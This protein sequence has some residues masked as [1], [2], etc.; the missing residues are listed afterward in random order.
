MSQM[1]NPAAMED[2]A[3]LRLRPRLRFEHSRY[4]QAPGTAATAR[5]LNVLH[6]GNGSSTRC[7]RIFPVLQS[8]SATPIRP[9]LCSSILARSSPSD[10]FA[11]RPSAAARG[12]RY[13][14]QRAANERPR[15]SRRVLAN[16]LTDRRIS[17]GMSA[18]LESLRNAINEVAV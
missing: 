4:R 9:P 15:N 5:T 10:A 1:R 13:I 18:S 8:R 12:L 2:V 3:L 14:P 17:P 6:I 11:G 7:P 16:A